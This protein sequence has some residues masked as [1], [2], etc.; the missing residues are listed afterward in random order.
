[1][2]KRK[3]TPEI[4]KW[5]KEGRGSGIGINYKTW[6]K[7]QDVSSLGRSTRLKEIK[8]VGNMNFIGFRTKIFLFE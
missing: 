1:M 8:R 4:E 7:I 3:R 2:S 5:I 6:L